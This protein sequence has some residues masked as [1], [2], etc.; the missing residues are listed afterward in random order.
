M[1]DEQQHFPDREMN[2][3]QAHTDLLH[4]QKFTV[5]YN[6]LQNSQQMLN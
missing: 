4:L 3:L 6:N 5:A 2:N 1:E